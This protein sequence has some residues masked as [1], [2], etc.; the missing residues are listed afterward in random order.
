VDW[1]NFMKK[2]YTLDTTLRDGA[3]AEKISFSVSDKL[4]IVKLLDE[5]GVSYI[6]AGNPSSN[7]KD[8]EFF[9]EVVKIPLKNAKLAAFGSTRKVGLKVEDD[10]NLIRLSQANTPVCVIFG[11][12]WDLHVRDVLNTTLEE[13]LLMIKESIEFLKKQGKE[14]IFDAEHFFDGYKNNPDYAIKVIKTAADSG[15]DCIVLCDTNGGCF[16][17]EVFEMTKVACGEVNVDIGIHTH[18]DSGLAVANSLMA[19]S[20]GAIHVQG[21]LNGIGERCGNANL[22][23]IIANLQIKK[24]Y[25]VLK[26]ENLSMLTSI[27]TAI[28]EISNISIS[29]TPYVS[30]GAFSHKAGMHIDAVLKNPISFEHIDPKL[31][32]NDRNFLVSEVAGKSAIMPI[33]K[34]VAPHLTKSSPEIAT[35]LDRLKELEYQ[36]YQFEAAEASLEIEIRKALGLYELSFIVD[37]LR[38]M[39]EQNSERDLNGYSSAFIKVIVGNEV[40]I[41]AADSDGPVHALDLALRQSLEKFYPVLRD[42][43]LSDYK[44]RVLNSEGATGAKVRVLIESTDGVD[45]WTTVGV[46]TDV[47]MAS[48]KALVDSIEYRLIKEKL[49]LN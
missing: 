44:V 48:K 21:T 32:G 40:A 14:V 9:K 22:S 10:I 33:I 17:E 23:T 20:A 43:R 49:K 16:P 24:G 47:I 2:I 42:V 41:T 27:C 26:P 12:S 13:N 29:G 8:I 6:E 36:G 39:I 11:K 19:V 5:L 7:I 35:I 15:A 37:R 25:D 45:S 18:N 46:S 31:V 38:I 4:K 3:Q 30:K 1:G 34:K 28:A